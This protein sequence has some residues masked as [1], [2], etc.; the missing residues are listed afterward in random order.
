MF[1]M[2]I[3]WEGREAIA[4]VPFEPE[5]VRKAGPIICR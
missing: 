3:L 5:W 1:G 4:Y 2:G